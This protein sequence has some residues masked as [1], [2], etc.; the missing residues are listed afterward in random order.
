MASRTAAL[1][2]QIPAA[3]APSGGGVDD[4]DEQAASA[5]NSTAACGD[6]ERARRRGITAPY[7]T[8]GAR[9]RLSQSGFAVG[10]RLRKARDASADR[11]H[12]L[13]GDG[14]RG[15]RPRDQYRCSPRWLVV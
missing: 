6:T 13:V 1:P 5:S 15:L 14:E 2:S 8:A 4:D 7:C 10:S 11:V 12:E 3:V 9:P